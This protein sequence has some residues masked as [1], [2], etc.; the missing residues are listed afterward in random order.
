H[1]FRDVYRHE[2][3]A[4]VHSNRM[5]HHFWE[6]GRAPRPRPNGTLFRAMLHSH[7]LFEQMPV[8]KRP[9]FDRT[10]HLSTLLRLSLARLYLRRRTINLPVRLLRRVLYPFVGTPQGVTGW[11]PP[12]VLPSPPPCG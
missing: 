1:V 10:S 6:N 2:A 11:R 4:I 9:F 5:S 8:N 3:L 12:E 7:D